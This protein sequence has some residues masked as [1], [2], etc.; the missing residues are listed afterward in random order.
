MGAGVQGKGANTCRL[1]SLRKGF[2]D[3][4][5]YAL[6]PV[7]SIM[8]VQPV[9]LPNDNVPSEV[10]QA[11][12]PM[13]PVPTI[14]VPA[15]AHGSQG[16]VVD[17][18]AHLLSQ[19]GRPQQLSQAQMAP[20]AVG[21]PH[22]QIVTATSEQQVVSYDNAAP[23]VNM[24]SNKRSRM[25]SMKQLDALVSKREKENP[26]K[27]K[28]LDQPNEGGDEH[29]LRNR[30][31]A[32]LFRQRE[33]E[34]TNQLMLKVQ[35]LEAKNRELQALQA[36][37]TSSKHFYP[38][39]R[40]SIQD[41]CQFNTLRSSSCNSSNSSSSSNSNSSSSSSSSSSSNNNN[42]NNNSKGQIR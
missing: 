6:E 20:F 35:Q 38:L 14:P 40:C 11:G 2:A 37:L 7:K 26:L 5:L 18:H 13:F 24:R 9:N 19:L 21:Q 27:S 36:E 10:P 12:Q 4:L 31:A 8:Q 28:A 17:L 25:L 22:Q 23:P 32:R 42:N 3:T 15:V 29:Q 33:E 34:Y 41:K 16:D 30:R 39:N 1:K